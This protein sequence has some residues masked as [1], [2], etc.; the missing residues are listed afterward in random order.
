MMMLLLVGSFSLAGCA[1]YDSAVPAGTGIG[2]AGGALIGYGLTGSGTGAAVG[3]GAGALAGALTG[4]AI[5][6]S[7][8]SA[9]PPPPATYQ[10]SPPQ[11]YSSPPQAYAPQ[12]DPTRGEFLNNTA[13]RIQVFVDDGIEPVWVNARESFPID[14]DI[15]IH[16][17]VANAYVETRFGDRLVGS[18]R[19]QVN[20][21]PRG[22]G[23][24]LRFE[25]RMFR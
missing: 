12:P 6:E 25:E 15:G 4:V 17:I 8:R 5:D 18:Y 20:V 21:D 1:T 11:R 23:W 7:R 14:L 2:A 3:A 13:W 19:R 16:E 22:S 24:S 10:A 9:A